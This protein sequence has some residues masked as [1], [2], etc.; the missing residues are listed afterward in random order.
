[1]R[2]V[3]PA[4]EIAARTLQQARIGRDSGRFVVV[5][6]AIDIT[7]REEAFF[8]SEFERGGARSR[9]VTFL[10]LADNPTIERLVTPS[11]AL[12]LRLG[13]LLSDIQ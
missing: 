4:N 5:F 3:Q 10:N 7:Q 8:I 13:A 11:F 6:A 12:S 2:T 9:T 1:M